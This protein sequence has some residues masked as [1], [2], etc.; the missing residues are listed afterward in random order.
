MILK[1]VGAD[2]S[3]LT[4]TLFLKML[5]LKLDFIHFSF[6]FV[7]LKYVCMNENEISISVPM[8][9]LLTNY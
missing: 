7:C 5:Q 4:T 1:S 9:N 6:N 2:A 3:K 8:T